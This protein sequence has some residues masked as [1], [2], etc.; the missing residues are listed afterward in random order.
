MYYFLYDFYYFKVWLKSLRGAFQCN[1]CGMVSHKKCV[2]KC[3]IQTV[4]EG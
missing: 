2:E 1:N 3:H 4:C